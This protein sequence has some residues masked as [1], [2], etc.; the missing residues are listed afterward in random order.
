MWGEAGN[1][2]LLGGTGVETLVGGDNDDTLN[3]GG[4]A[5]TLDG[6]AG[7]DVYLLDADATDTLI[8][9]GG[10]D[11]V[12]SIITRN[13]QA[14]TDIENLVLE[15]G[16]NVHGTG[17]NA[18]NGIIGSAGTNVLAG[19]AG[20]DTLLGRDGNDYLFGQGGRDNLRGDGGNDVFVYQVVGDSP[21]GAGLRDTILDL[22]DSGDDVIDLTAIAGLDATSFIDGDVFSAPN[23]V[24]IEQVGLDVLVQINSSGMSGAEGEILI[25]NATTGMGAGQVD[26]G[27]FLL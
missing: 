4:G 5:D 22:D 24:R 21:A 15:G 8:D 19:L 16:A 9:A 17:T 27:D 25:A 11:A 12:H 6:G 26:A 7:N 3:G 23:Q 20:N 13:L 2:R 14:W 10:T 18:A 1:D